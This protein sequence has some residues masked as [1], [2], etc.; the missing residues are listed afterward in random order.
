MT[1]ENTNSAMPQGGS[2]GRVR[3]PT[4]RANAAGRR[5]LFDLVSVYSLGRLLCD[6]EVASGQSGRPKSAEEL[7]V[8]LARFLGAG[9][10]VQVAL[11]R[12]LREYDL[13]RPV[14]EVGSP[15][16]FNDVSQ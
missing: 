16:I 6:L 9:E 5:T 15:H 3:Q 11:R 13:P 2:G 7:R 4:R 1:S 14:R 10:E 12:F 8:A